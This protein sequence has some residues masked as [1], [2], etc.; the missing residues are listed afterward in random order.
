MVMVMFMV[1]VLGLDEEIVHSPYRVAGPTWS[2]ARARARH[3]PT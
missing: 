2:C 1:T 3:R